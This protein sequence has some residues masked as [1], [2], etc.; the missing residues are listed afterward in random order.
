[1]ES[2]ISTGG[3]KRYSREADDRAGQFRKP[4]ATKALINKLQLG[5][6]ET[7]GLHKAVMALQNFNTRGA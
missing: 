7:Q 2:L 5:A 3:R 4:G 1:M 6:G